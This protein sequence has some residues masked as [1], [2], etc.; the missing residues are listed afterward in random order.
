MIDFFGGLINPHD[1]KI[2]Q[3]KK[4][5]DKILALEDKIKELSDE[6]LKGKTQEFRNRLNSGESLDN[7][8][9]EAFAVVREASFRILGMKHFPVQLMGGIVLH[10]G[11]ISEMKTGEGKTLV[12]TLPTYLNALTGDGVFVITVNDYLAARDK[13]EMGKVHEFLG[14]KVGLIKRGM[15]VPEKKDAYSCDVIYGTNS[16]FGFD[17]LRDNLAILKDTVVQRKLNYAIID[18][19]DSILIDEARTPLIMTGEAHRP[20][21]YYITVDRFV[22]SLKEEDYEKDTEKNT[23]N[24]TESGMDKAERIFGLDN[25]A[26]IKN[27][28]LLHHIRQAL[29]ANHIIQKDKDYVVKDGEIVIVDKF[30]G[31][32]MEGRRFSSGLHQ[33]LEAKEG[34]EIQKESKTMAMIT[35]QN[36]F[37]MFN[38]IAGMTGTAY[39]ERQEFKDIYGMDVICIPTNKPIKRKDKTDLLFK[40]EETKF[41][42]IVEE[43]EKRHKKGQPVLIGTIYIDKSEMLSDMLKEK[44]IPHKILNAKQDK[45]EAEIISM[46]GQRGAVTIATNMAGRGTDIKLGEGVAELGGLFV[47]GTER[48]DSRRIDNQLRGRSGRQGDPGES[49]FYISLE[50]S[51]FK[52]VNPDIMERVHKIVDKINLQDGQAIQDKL[53][54]QAIEGVQKSVEI[55]NYN[56]R[57]AT[58]E[59]DKILNKQRETIYNERNKI[60]NGEDMSSFIKEIIKDLI[61]KL[62]DDYTSMSEYPEE[63]DLK[64]IQNYLNENLY[65]NNR[66]NFENLSTEEIEELDRDDVKEKIL[67]EALKIYSEK[68]EILGEKQLRYLERLTLMKSI[69]EKWIDHLDL[70]DQLRQG[71]GFQHIGGQNPIRIFNKEAFDLFEDMLSE[72]KELTIKSLFLLTGIT[73]G[74]KKKKELSEEE[75]ME[76]ILRL[77]DKYKINRKYITR[78]PSNTPLIKFNVDI[79]AVEE[80]NV[81]VDLYY[82]DNGFEEKIEN[83]HQNLTVTGVFSVEFEKPKDKDWNIGWH[84]IKVSVSGQEANVIN[85]LVADPKDQIAN[86]VV[87]TKFFSNKLNIISFEL[88]LKGYNKDKIGAGLIYNKDKDTLKP[89]ELPVKNEKVKVAIP[90]PENGWKKGLHELILLGKGTNIIIPFR[91]VDEYKADEEELNIDFKFKIKKGEVANMLG[92]LIYLEENKIVSTLPITINQSGTINVKFKKKENIWKKGKYQFRLIAFN[93]VVL[94]KYILV[95]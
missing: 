58:L 55:A 32:L 61:S 48:H 68:E 80:I 62:V 25:I 35:Y 31:R 27:T 14:L 45:D 9:E 81:D 20:S 65:F 92:E 28:E 46:A 49:Q 79:N 76:N 83:Y 56:I 67:D 86:N 52:K 4:R 34:L 82:M 39:T 24:L 53:V 30:T 15:S 69:D 77:E 13:E 23:V 36:Y 74:N 8:L 84:Q 93:S 89:F 16:E 43:V 38:K 41:K 94:T 70:V 3:L 59:F 64:G 11:N 57:K 63:W 75:K 2:N 66:V 91:V 12:A 72:I 19:V 95:S 71:I 1:R 10:E 22:K 40:T 26:D 44:N 37:K 54:A 85:F 60:L 5:V 21:Q 18:E 87:K 73:G 78:I 17:Y 47:L 50:D 33:A 42:S 29:S 88:L 90:R 51:L 7:I 6:E